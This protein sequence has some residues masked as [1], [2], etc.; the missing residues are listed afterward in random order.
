MSGILSVHF[1]SQP[2]PGIRLELQ[3]YARDPRLLFTVINMNLKAFN[4]PE[5]TP[6][7]RRAELQKKKD[8][9]KP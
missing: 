8:K 5:E 9:M 6:K 1:I 4:N 7:A 3:K 2:T